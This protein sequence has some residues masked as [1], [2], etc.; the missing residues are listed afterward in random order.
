MTDDLLITRCWQDLE[1][2]EIEIECKTEFIIARGK[3]YTTDSLIDDLYNKIEEFLSGDTNNTYW[4]NGT[5][6]DITTPC[7]TFQFLHKDKAGHVLIEVFMEIDDGGTLCTHN[8]CFFVNTE[9]GLLYQF[10]ENLL[11][12]KNPHLG[13]QVSLSNTEMTQ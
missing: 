5:R 6:G 1:F 3:I 2:F 12:L 9:I 7:V 8:C 10:K 4:Q 13:I 11:K